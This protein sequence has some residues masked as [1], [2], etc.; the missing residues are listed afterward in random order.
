[1]PANSVQD[2]NPNP[3]PIKVAGGGPLQNQELQGEMGMMQVHKEVNISLPQ[4]GPTF[5]F[6]KF[7]GN[8]EQMKLKY[9]ETFNKTQSITNVLDKAWGEKKNLEFFDKKPHSFS[10]DFMGND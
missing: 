8:S 10:T 1:M 4:M 3:A 9:M 7:R 2:Y 6:Y 5:N